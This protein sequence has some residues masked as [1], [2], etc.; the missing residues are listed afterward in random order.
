M[1]CFSPDFSSVESSPVVG[2]PF[3]SSCSD[4]RDGTY[5]NFKD[6]AVRQF[7]IEDLES[8]DEAEV[9]VHMQKAKDIAFE[10]NKK[11][12][13]IL[14]HMSDFKTI[15]QKQRV[16][17][18]YIGAVY[19]MSLQSIGFFFLIQI[20]G[21]FTGSSRS[22]FPYLLAAKEDLAFGGPVRS[23]FLP[24]LDQTRTATGSFIFKRSQK[25]D[26]T[27]QNRFCAVRSYLKTGCDRLGHNRSSTDLSR[28]LHVL[29]S[30]IIQ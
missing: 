5:E 17:R 22:A 26:R 30:T 8:D 29:H 11:G 20:T 15:R 7:G 28:I 24:F 21:D 3:T 13:L 25:P 9:P 1:M 27:A 12:D 19:R 10:R 6:W 2:N 16:V 23:G 14:P 18:G 4:W